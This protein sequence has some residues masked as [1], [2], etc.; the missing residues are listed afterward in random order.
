MDQPLRSAEARLQR[1]LGV[2]RNA[3]ERARLKPDNCEWDRQERRQLAD[4]SEHKFHK[5]SKAFT[6]GPRSS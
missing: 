3:V 6:S 4:S 2:D 1:D 5:L